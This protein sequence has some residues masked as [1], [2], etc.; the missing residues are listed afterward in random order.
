MARNLD[1]LERIRGNEYVRLLIHCEQEYDD[2]MF[3]SEDHQQGDA[4][5]TEDELDL[6]WLWRDR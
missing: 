5:D 1:P 4:F 2:R 6:I 3:V